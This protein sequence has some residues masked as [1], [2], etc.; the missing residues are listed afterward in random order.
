MT[1]IH[2]ALFL[3]AIAG[4][5]SGCSPQHKTAASPE[6]T[7]RVVV[8]TVNYPLMYFAARIGG[9]DVD[10]FFPAPP[11][12]D[13]AFWSPD[14]A[15]VSAYQ[16]ADLI[17]LNGANYARWIHKV[18]L[19]ESRFVHTTKAVQESYIAIEEGITHSHGPGDTHSHDKTAITTWLDPEIAIAQAAAILQ[20]LIEVRP[21]RQDEFVQNYAAVK[22]DLMALD[23]K[24]EQ[25]TH[26]ASREP[27]LFSHPVYQYSQRKY[28]LHGE[29]VHWEPDV[30]PPDEDWAQLRTLL[31]THPARWMIWEGQPIEDSVKQLLELG[32]QSVVFNPCGNRPDEGDWLQVMHDNAEQLAQVYAAAPPGSSSE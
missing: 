31:E 16:K 6:N 15:T 24:F 23:E 30:L 3:A 26:D 2:L 12:E 13:P 20:A 19:P 10:A 25:A 27:V 32:I 5:L 29:S 11:D 1:R 22:S 7:R 28:E 17:L 9:D 14:A 21:G 4:M 18:T 8:Y